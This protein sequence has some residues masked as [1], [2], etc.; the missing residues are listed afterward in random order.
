[1][2][3]IAQRTDQYGGS[4]ENR[5]RF[6]GEILEAVKSVLPSTSIG[7]RISP[8]GVYGDMGSTDFREQ[9]SYTVAELDKH[10][11]AYLHVMDGLGFGFH[12][13]GEPFTL[14]DARKLFKGIIIGN[15]GYTKETAEAA[16]ASGNADM[17]AFGRPFISN[18]DLPA[19]FANNWPL[20]P[21]ATYPQWY[22]GGADGYTDFPVYSA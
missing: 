2:P 14:A 12:K 17:I 22:N 1:M 6:L 3:L 8:N 15:V 11:L 7:V 5:Y 20:N 18:P 4:V 19:R 10:N 13:L 21:D 16:I 9:F